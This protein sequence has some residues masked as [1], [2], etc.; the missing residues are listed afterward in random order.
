[1]MNNKTWIAVIVGAVVISVTGLGVQ[2]ITASSD[3]SQLTKE[4]IAEIVEGKYPGEV[5]EIELERENGQL[6][7]EA[8]LKGPKGDYEVTLDAFTG[9]VVNLEEKP[10]QTLQNDDVNPQTNNEANEQTH[11]NKSSRSDGEPSENSEE[12]PEPLRIS[13]DQA[14]TIALREVHGTIKDRESDVI[15]YEFE[16]ET[17][18]GVA[19]IE[20]DALT[21]EIITISWDD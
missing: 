14:A 10:P 19:E 6:V 4:E 21:G 9:D 13:I 5:E 17:D 7:Y 18:S 12:S 11:D 20:I 3:N 8:E 1:M 16:I 15:T 2:H